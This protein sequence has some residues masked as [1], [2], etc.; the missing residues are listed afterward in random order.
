MN[1]L[2]PTNVKLHEKYDLKGSIYKRK[3]SEEERKRDLP[4]LKDNDF[5]SLHNN[6]L[7]LEPFFYDQLMQTIEDDVRVCFVHLKTF[8][9][10]SSRHFKIL[11]SFD[12]M[13]YSL[14]VAVHNITEEMKSTQKLNILPPSLLSSPTTTERTPSSDTF[15][16]TSLST[17]EEIRTTLS[18]DSGI[19]MTNV[20]NL[21]TYI[22]YIRVIEFI[23]AQQ[24]PSLHTS[25]VSNAEHFPSDNH[26]HH[27]NTE[28]ASIKTVKADLNQNRNEHSINDN[29]SNVSRNSKSPTNH[30]DIPPS[31]HVTHALM[32]GEVWYNR[33][34]LSRLA[35]YV[36]FFFISIGLSR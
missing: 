21:P 5:K 7:I 15:T 35:M 29:Q 32:G 9:F 30:N 14:L 27:E 11:A 19:A 24:E 8:R 31:F 6:G 23:R 34:N 18:T 1:N 26:H 33:Q 12:I 28:T 36:I 4:T 22:Q 3:A 17:H 16:N 20:P 13:D 10:F 25:S 2:I